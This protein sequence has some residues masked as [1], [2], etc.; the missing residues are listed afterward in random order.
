MAY[1]DTNFKTGAIDAA[2]GGQRA[3][4]M[5]VPQHTFQDAQIREQQ[6]QSVDAWWTG[7]PLQYWPI[8]SSGIAG[9]TVVFDTTLQI[10]GGGPGYRTLASSGFT[11][12]VTVITGWLIEPVSSGAKARVATGGG[13][14]PPSVTGLSGTDSGPITVDTTSGRLRKLVSGE[15]VYGYCDLNGNCHLFV[16]GFAP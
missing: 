13:Y 7:R 15:P 2:F 6:R 11:Q 12:D 14:L 1:P 8:A 16:V 9:D 3:N 4:A 5:G 10:V